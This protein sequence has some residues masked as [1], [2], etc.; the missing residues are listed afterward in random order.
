MALPPVPPIRGRELVIGLVTPVGTNT[1]VVAERVRAALSEWNYRSLIVKL[2]DFFNKQT[3][4]PQGEFEDERVRRLIRAGDDWCTLHDD[5]AAVARLAILDIRSK[6]VAIHRQAGSTETDEALLGKPLPRLAYII[7]SLKRPG[8]VELLRKIY[9]PQFVLLGC[10]ASTEQRI[11]NLVQRA[12]S[13]TGNEGRQ[14]IAHDLMLLDASEDDLMGQRVNE[15]FPRSDYFLR[16]DEPAVRFVSLLFGDPTIAPKTGEL[17]MYL[18]HATS[19]RS[20]ATSRRVGAA[21][22]VGD[23]VAAVG[24]NDVPPEELPDIAAGEDPNER[25]KSDLLRD[26]I[27]RLRIKGIIPPASPTDEADFQTIREALEGSQLM[28]VIEYQR[29]I[30]AEVAAISDAARR[31]QPVAGAD[32][33]CTT[34]P[35]HLCFKSA[36]AAD[37]NRIHYIEPYPKSR[38]ELMFPRSSHRLTP[39]EGISPQMYVRAF[40][41][42]SVKPDELGRLP[43]PDR[44]TQFPVLPD[45]L[46]VEEIATEEVKAV[47]TLKIDLATGGG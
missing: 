39:Y 23:S 16:S 1:G 35:C 9:G 25:Q 47:S 34:Y 38:A 13:V 21:L 43:L 41:R 29:P 22:V 19:L 42:L 7:H 4:P 11:A 10:Q 37:L 8:E 31:G 20:L 32:L 18:A 45:P 5:A 27:H 40:E 30:H 28:S 12:L 26:T 6:R 2:T 15:T 14:G 3:S 36:L 33:Y 44:A 17:A 24:W 46:G